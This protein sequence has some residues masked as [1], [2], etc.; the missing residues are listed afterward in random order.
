MAFL[1]PGIY[2]L[3]I[4]CTFCLAQDGFEG[5]AAFVSAKPFGLLSS[6]V[7]SAL[8]PRVSSFL[9]GNPIA[10]G[11]LG[12]LRAELTDT[13]F[14]YIVVGGG[15]TGAALGTRLAEAGNKVAIIEAGSFFE[16]SKPLLATTPTGDI[17]GVGADIRDSI[18]TT[19]WKFQTEPQ[20]GANGRRVH[21]ARGKCLGGSSALNFMIYHRPT[22]GSCDAWAEAVGDDT[23]R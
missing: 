9:L 22:V 5:A 12:S 6:V 17:I 8:P 21:F 16:T 23:Y 20:A 1:A 3:L 13:E 11:G 2:L 7:G 14:D 10:K 15:N 4:L 18:G 19:D